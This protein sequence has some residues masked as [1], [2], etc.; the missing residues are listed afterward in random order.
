MYQLPAFRPA[1]LNAAWG[2]TH[3]R[4]YALRATALCLAAAPRRSTEQR[5]FALRSS[6]FAS[7]S[8]S[9]YSSRQAIREERLGCEQEG[10]GDEQVP[11]QPLCLGLRFVTGTNVAERVARA[12]DPAGN[13][14]D[15]L[16]RIHRG[17]VRLAQI[18]VAGQRHCRV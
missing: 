12:G 16:A 8:V 6:P 7:H 3:T 10:A 9:A 2:P 5:A 1:F 17:Q 14:G 13:R 18:H 11:P 4:S 15:E